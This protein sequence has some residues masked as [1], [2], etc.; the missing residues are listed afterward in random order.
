MAPIL[1]RLLMEGSVGPDVAILQKLLGVDDDGEFGP[2]TE[3][4]VI[5]FQ[6]AHGL[7]ADGIVGYKTWGA[8]HPDASVPNPPQAD[9]DHHKPPCVWIPS[10]NYSSRN[11]DRITN[12]IIHHTESFDLNGTVAWFRNP[13]SR[14]SAHYVMDL[15]GSIVQMVRDA[16]KA[17]H[18]YA[19]NSYTIGIEVVHANAM[20]H[21]KPAQEK[22][23]ILLCKS[24]MAEYGVSK[25]GV[26]KSHGQYPQ[27]NTDCN[28]SLF[29][30]D[31]S[32]TAAWVAKN[33]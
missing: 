28:G 33:L 7:V 16:D 12:I 13:A 26:S 5:S 8:L 23:L 31:K 1:S 32:A 3:A 19:N 10:P 30:S 11:G 15:D 27:N 6:V 29:G 14:V 18:C 21:I 2:I 24:L 22:A 9:H 25:A 4:A 20:G 17:W